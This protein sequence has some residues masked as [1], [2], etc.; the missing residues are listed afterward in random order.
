MTDPE[1]PKA[2]PPTL[3]PTLPPGVFPPEAVELDGFRLRRATLADDTALL[4]AVQASFAELHPWMPWCTE[5]IELADQRAFIE[6]SAEQWAS[7]SAFNW[8]VVDAGGAVIGSVSIV[9]R[10]GPGGVE[11]GYWLRTDA[12]GRGVMTRAAAWVTD[13][14]LSLPGVDRVEIHCDAANTRSANVARR[15]GFRLAHTVTAE[16]T[17]PGESGLSQVWVT[18]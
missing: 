8:F 6:R 5:P 1:P 7:G 13:I 3:P 15:L 12:T 14:A 4:Q 2:A 9:D 11:V 18:P 17:A 16:P 10:I